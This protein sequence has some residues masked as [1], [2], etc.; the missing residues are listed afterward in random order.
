MYITQVERWESQTHSICKQIVN[1]SRAQLFTNWKRG[2]SHNICSHKIQ[3]IHS[4]TSVYIANRPQTTSNYF[5]FQKGLLTYTANRL[6]RWGTILLNYDFQI[7]YLSTNKIGHAGGLFR[8]IPR[9]TKTFEDTVIAALRSENEVENTLNS[10]IREL[11]VSLKE[12]KSEAVRD[13]FIREIKAKLLK[14]NTK[15]EEIYSLCDNILLYSERVV[16]PKTLQKRILHDFHT[17]HPGINRMKNLMRSYVFWPGMDADVTDMVS[18][19]KG[20]I[21]TAKSP[22]TSQEPWPKAGRTWSR[23]HIDFAGPIDKWYYLVVV[24]DSNS[25]WSEVFQM[26]RPTSTN[27]VNMLHELFAR[28]SVVDTIVSDNGTQFTSKEFEHFCAT[29]Q[30]EHIRIPPYHPRSNG[31]A[32]RFEDTLKRAL[33]KAIGT[34]SKKSLQLFLQ[35]YRI[36]QNKSVPS[37]ISPAESMLTRRIRSVFDKLIPSK[38]SHIPAILV[39]RRKFNKND[40]VFYKNNKNDTTTWE[41]GI[42]KEPIGNMIYTVQGKKFIHNRHVN[43]LQKR[44]T[45]EPTETPQIEEDDLQDLCDTFD[46]QMPQAEQEARVNRKRKTPPQFIIDPKRKKY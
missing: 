26:K 5:S 19:C 30:V 27:T 43:Q 7:Q 38:K 10:T 15:I 31:Q 33:K 13:K 11:P 9:S 14:K 28:Y 23:I 32:E 37:T 24:V 17:G 16:I 12:I 41:H 1:S 34:P 40:K 35:V 8:L 25:K 42:I 21:L 6:L 36:T 29:F 44:I 4:W 22:P 45:D 18:K 46:L 2:S 20:C 3:Q 39:P